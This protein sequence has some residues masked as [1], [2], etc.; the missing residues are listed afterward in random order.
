MV[1]KVYRAPVLKSV[2][3]ATQEAEIRK[4]M[5]LNQPQANSLRNPIQKLNHENCFK[6]A[7]DTEPQTS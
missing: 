6:M 3:L 2:I 4:I 7:T 5:V 1:I